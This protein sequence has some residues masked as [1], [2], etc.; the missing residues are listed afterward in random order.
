MA[1]PNPGHILIYGIPFHIYLGVL[2][3][4]LLTTTAV[5]G[6]LV[7]KGHRRFKFAWHFKLALTTIVV[8]II[9][10]IF[11]IWYTFF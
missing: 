10:G 1:F 9:H 11:A 8:G 2:T 3:F 6:Y 4:I 7:L 5:I